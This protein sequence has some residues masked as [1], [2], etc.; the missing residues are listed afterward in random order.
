VTAAF[1]LCGVLVNATATLIAKITSNGN[2]VT[3]ISVHGA[4]C[5]GIGCLASRGIEAP[6][7]SQNL[8]PELILLWQRLQVMCRSLRTAPPTLQCR[9]P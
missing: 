6:H 4:P 9:R 1:P 8:L 3:A 7:V 2:V 5:V